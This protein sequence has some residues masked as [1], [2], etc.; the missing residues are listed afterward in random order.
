MNITIVGC[1]NIGTQLA[2]HCAEKNNRVI[3]YGSKP[4]RIQKQLFIQNEKGEIIH[5]G[6]IYQATKDSEKAFSD[7]DLIIIT[8]PAYCMQMLS[9]SISP[10][11]NE[12]VKICLVPGTGG[13][14]CAFGKSIEKGAIVFGLQRVPSVA[15]LLKY[16]ETVIATGYRNEL[17]VASLPKKH[18]EECRS[19]IED[20]MEI[21]CSLLPNYLNL[22]LTPSNPILHTVRLRCL[23]EDYTEG[24][25]YDRNPLF[26]EEWNDKTSQLIFKCDYEVQQICSSLTDFDLSYVRSLKQHYESN[27]P[28]E[29]TAKIRSI[30]GFKGLSSPMKQT[31]NGYVPNFDSRYFT[32]D[33]PFGLSI[34][35]QIADFVGVDVP[36]M[37]ETYNWYKSIC[38]INDEFKYSDYD[39]NNLE[40]FINFYKY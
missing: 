12:G 3:M 32:A 34:L 35:C 6:S 24:K 22:T 27:T 2:V 10:F 37:K 8:M 15:R 9:E 4:E 11:V 13:G 23:F 21:K 26:Y 20:L 25:V 33:F 19:L 29:L 39:V 18:G 38:V 14:E 31:E 40:T 16:G 1:G 36:N 17:F 28:A 5:S 30:K 7:A